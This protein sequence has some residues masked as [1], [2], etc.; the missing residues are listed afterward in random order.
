MEGASALPGGA[1]ITSN[2]TAGT[3]SPTPSNRSDARGTITTI[4]INAV[5]QDQFWKGYVGNISGRLSLDDATGNTIYD[6]PISLSKE[7]E[8]YVSRAS[9]PVFGSVGCANINNITREEGYYGMTTTQSDNI[10]KTFNATSHQQ[11]FVGNQ[12]ITANSCRSTA[13][14]VNDSPQTLDGNQ[15]FQEIVLQDSSFNLVYTTMINASK[16]GF[17]TLDYDFQMIVPESVFN[18][19]TT[20]FFFTE[21]G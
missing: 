14:Y 11:F 7:G 8:V 5:Q 4:I 10:N 18:S 21:L 19:S 3:P 12:S 2:S 16:D 15:Y 20:Y 9:S 6:W 17:D 1:T 13:T